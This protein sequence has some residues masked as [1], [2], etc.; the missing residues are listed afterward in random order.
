MEFL[1]KKFSMD[2]EWKFSGGEVDLFQEDSHNVVYAQVKAGGAFGPARKKAY[3]DSAWQ[4]VN[5][6]H[7]YIREAEFSPDAVSVQ[8][9][10]VMTDAWYRKTF[11]VDESLRGKHALLVF[12][13]ISKAAKIY[14]NGSL[15]GRCFEPYTETVV[16]VTDRLYYGGINT[17]AVFVDGKTLSGWWYEGAGIYRHVNLYVKDELHIA[18]NGIWANPVL[19]DPAREGWT[20]EVEVSLENSTYEE[21]TGAVRVR[22]ADGDTVLGE[23][24]SDAVCCPADGKAKTMVSIPVTAPKRWNVDDPNLYSVR[25]DLLRDGESVDQDSV[26]I[27][28]RTFRLDPDKGFFLN[29]RPLK[30]KGTC[31]HQDHAGVGVAVPDSIQYFRIRRLKEMGSNAYRCSH[32]LP[33]REILDACD[34][35]GMI[36][37]DENRFLETREDVR[38]NVETMVLRD[39][40]HPSVIF[41][42]IFNEEGLQNTPEGAAIFRRLRSIVRKYDP[43]RPVLGAVNDD[44]HPGGAGDYM[45]VLGR[46]YSPSRVVR[47][48]AAY[49][50]KMILGSENNSAVTTRGCYE[51]DREGAHVLNNYDEEVVPWGDTVRANWKVVRDN[52][53]FAGVFLWTGFDYRGE[54]TPFTWPSCSSQFGIMDTCGFAKDSYYFNQAVFLD[55]PMIHIL[56]HWNW[57]EGKTVRVMTVSNCDK[58]ELILNGRSLGVRDND[59]CEQN[60]WSVPF[61]AGKISAVGYRN[62]VA[63]AHAEQNTAGDPVAVRLVPDRTQIGNGG[64][65]T[66]PVRVSVVDAQGI[67]VPTASHLIR[68]SVEGDGIIAGVGN[69]DPNS[70]EPDHMPYRHLYCGLCQVLVTADLNATALTL[71]ASC[72]GLE[73]ASVAFEVVDQPRPDYIS[74]KPNRAVSGILTSVANAEEKPDPKRVYA[75]NDMNSFAPVELDAER[76]GRYLPRGF[77]R[78]WRELRI[79]VELPEI[80]PENGVPSLEFASVIC[81]RMEIYLDGELIFEATPEFKE[82]VSV[83]LRIRDRRAFELR[84]LLLAKSDSAVNGVGGSLTLSVLEE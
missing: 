46:N 6:P 14:L 42:S 48:H 74:S 28:F 49:P 8:G 19:T 2:R 12:D 37:M 84:C 45:D 70:H 16:D 36:V 15:V 13:G 31:N 57:E 22:L 68:F 81:E 20:V 72:E 7:D 27:G 76:F 67:E 4:I 26:R 32:N 5:L 34:E 55:E 64:Q 78:G 40:N 3:D 66:V 54:P 50:D 21:R 83:P 77:S 18:H 33:A 79:P 11:T 10:R 52:E 38:R 43:T 73:S 29:D 63:V 80:L 9:Y 71:T 58:V 44:F 61:E 35:Y 62:G 1:R 51:S 75:E 30:L 24:V 41:Y 59:P 39:R 65:D 47:I 56:P 17:L 23:A 69:G 53:F 60:E 25:V 82:S